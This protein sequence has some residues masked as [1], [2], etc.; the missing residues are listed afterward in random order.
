MSFILDALKKSEIERR[1]G[2][3]PGLEHA[4][5]YVVAPGR[6]AGHTG[7]AVAAG[8]GMLVIGLVLG[9]W[10]PWQPS[11]PLRPAWAMPAAAVLQMPAAIVQPVI[12][13]TYPSAEPWSV[14]PSQSMMPSEQA[15][16]A[17][18]Q[19]QTKASA[20]VEAK[21]PS[22]PAPQPRL[23]TTP[24]P[25]N[26]RAT[27]PGPA[28]DADAKAKAKAV[29]AA[30]ASIHVMDYRELPAEIRADLP[31]VVFGGYAGVDEADVRI[32]F[33]NN[34]LVKEGEEVSPGLKLEQVGREGVVLG[35]KDHHFRPVQ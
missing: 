10:R 6:P 32:A 22:R 33:I 27:N 28:A 25:R 4:S 7:L 24:V 1:A 19:A 20:A 14:I 17:P 21:A 9:G 18:V 34:L 31:K 5:T 13:A 29:S 35:Y 11:Q 26:T 12:G 2:I 30:V 3:A 23:Q 16:T 15:A 8:V